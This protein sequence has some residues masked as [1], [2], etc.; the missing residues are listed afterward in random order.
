MAREGFSLFHIDETSPL[1]DLIVR[2]RDRSDL[3]AFETL[4]SL[5]NDAIN[6]YLAHTIGNDGVGCELAQET[7]FKAW[8]KLPQLRQ[9][10]SF[11]GWLYRIASNC[12][13]DYLRTLPQ[14]KDVSL[15]SCYSLSVAG[16][17][18]ALEQSEL[19][20]QAL[21][22]VPAKYREALILYTVEGLPQRLIATML[23]INERS[24]SKYI[25]R[26]K[27]YLR[28]HYLQL[29]G[30]ERLHHEGSTSLHDLGRETGTQA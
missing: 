10:E 1:F 20:K 7:F 8:T 18:E 17:E 3:R 15:D 27:D 9:V 25:A 30:K 2:A 12:A 22:Q 19:L 26:G 14:L 29:T 23:N 16:P 13:H 28:K 6:R 4:F 24:V 5:Y 11:P 21:A